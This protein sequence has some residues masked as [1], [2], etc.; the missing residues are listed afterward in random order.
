[1]AKIQ[2]ERLF[3]PNRFGPF[4]IFS[5]HFSIDSETVRRIVIVV[6][7]VKPFIAWVSVD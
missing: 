1:M 7:L 3:Y 6:V 4:V 2:C 5:P